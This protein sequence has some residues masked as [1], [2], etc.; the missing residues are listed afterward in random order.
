MRSSQPWPCPARLH[1]HQGACA[2][3]PPARS[4][5]GS[6]ETGG[7][8]PVAARWAL[9]PRVPVRLLLGGLPVECGLR[10]GHVPTP[11]YVV[12]RRAGDAGVPG[13]GRPAAAGKDE[14]GTARPERVLPGLVCQPAPGRGRGR[15]AP[16]WS[17]PSAASSRAEPGVAPELALPASDIRAAS[18]AVGGGAWPVPARDAGTRLPRLVRD[19][20]ATT[21]TRSYAAAGGRRGEL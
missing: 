16:G 10:P 12:R 2:D 5:P 19:A 14:G 4:L 21:C 13:E 6:L 1:P 20:A 8:F 11:R 18:V 7:A 17:C 9:R 3:P 15:A